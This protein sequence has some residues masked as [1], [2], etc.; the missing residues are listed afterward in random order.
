MNRSMAASSSNRR[1]LDCRRARFIFRRTPAPSRATGRDPRVPQNRTRI[2]LPFRLEAGTPRASKW[3]L[4]HELQDI[5]VAFA[6]VGDFI[7]ERADEQYS[8]ASHRT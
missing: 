7:Y 3:E 1:P 6:A 8:Q 2:R 4:Y 5:S